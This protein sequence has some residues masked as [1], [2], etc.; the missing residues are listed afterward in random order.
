MT[1]QRYRHWGQLHQLRFFPV[2]TWAFSGLA[3]F[4]IFNILTSVASGQR[5]FSSGVV[6]AIALIMVLTLLVNLLA[7]D[8]AVATFDRERS[9]I[10]LRRYGLRG[11]YAADRSLSDLESLS[12]KVMRGAYCELTLSFRSGERLPL[13]TSYVLMLRMKT[14]IELT[15]ALGVRLEAERAAK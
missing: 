8:F 9:T 10:A 11:R 3:I 7:G 15:K 2:L 1:I 12:V 4:N 6:V 5:P 13:T 14:V